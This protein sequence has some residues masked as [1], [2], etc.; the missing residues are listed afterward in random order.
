MR[1]L[2]YDN[3]ES[4]QNKKKVEE[5]HLLRFNRVEDYG[6]H[7]L[8]CMHRRQYVDNIS[9]T[10]QLEMELFDSVKDPNMCILC[11]SYLQNRN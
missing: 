10:P 3:K 8:V 1:S 7:T 4:R 11:V 5:L 2:K 6:K 9:N